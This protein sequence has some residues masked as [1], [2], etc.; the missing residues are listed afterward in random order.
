MLL[1]ELDHLQAPAALVL[2][3][4]EWVRLLASLEPTECLDPITEAEVQDLLERLVKQTAT[5]PLD[6][7]TLGPIHSETLWGFAALLDWLMNTETGVR[8]QAKPSSEKPR[9]KGLLWVARS[10]QPFPWL[11][12]AAS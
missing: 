12:L 11:A 10:H 8:T 4:E 5:L 2:A 9:I 1:A 6:Y 7:A 3:V